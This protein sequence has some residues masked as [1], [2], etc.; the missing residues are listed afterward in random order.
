VTFNVTE[1]LDN[2]EKYL[3]DPTL[4]VAPY[5]CLVTGSMMGKSRLIKEMTRQ[6]PTIFICARE[7]PG[8]GGFPPTTPK[9]MIWF[10]RGAYAVADDEDQIKGDAKGINII[11][12]LQYS[13]FLI[14]TLHILALYLT[15]DDFLT[16]YEVYKYASQNDYSWMWR[17]F[18]DIQT[19]EDEKYVGEF[20]GKV[21]EGVKEEGAGCFTTEGAKNYYKQKY[22]IT[23]TNAYNVVKNNLAKAGYDVKRKFTLLFV[24][25]EARQFCQLA[26]EDG[27]TLVDES[28]IF[29]YTG[30]SPKPDVGAKD[31]FSGFRAL[32]RAIRL[33]C[34]G[35]EEK[36]IRLF[37]LFTDTT[38]RLTNF[39][40]LPRES[41]SLREVQLELGV[42]GDQQFEPLMYFTTIDAYA[43]IY[44]SCTSVE[45]V[46]DPERLVNFGRAGWRDMYYIHTKKSVSLASETAQAK[47]VNL[48]GRT[49]IQIPWKTKSPSRAILIKL[50]AVLAPRISLTAGPYTLEASE[51]VASHMAVLVKT[52]EDRH[53]TRMF[54][55]SE[56][57]SAE[58]AAH[59]LTTFGWSK[60]LQ[61][62]QHYVQT[63]IVDAG[64]RGELLSKIVCLMA[65]DSTNTKPMEGELFPF[66]R[67]IRVG[68]F[69]NHLISFDGISN[70]P[71]NCS[72][73]T[74]TGYILA[75]V[76]SHISRQKLQKFLSGYV[77]FTHFAR[78]DYIVNIAT[79]AQFFNRGAAIMCKSC[80]PGYDHIIPVM[81]DDAN[82]AQFGPLEGQWNAKQL[83]HGRAGLSGIFIDSKNYTSD[84]N[85][86]THVQH[87]C[88]V[89]KGRGKN[90][91]GEPTD[92]VFLSIIQDFGDGENLTN[93]VEIG[94]CSSHG[95]TLRQ[96]HKNQTQIVMRGVSER[97]YECLKWSNE[98]EQTEKEMNNRVRYL[99]EL[100]SA[101]TNFLDFQK[102]EGEAER[103][104][105]I[106]RAI[107]DFTTISL[108]QGTDPK[109]DA[110]WAKTR[111]NVHEID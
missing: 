11:P 1:I 16:K 18:A 79:L 28:D 54:Y 9:L 8:Q 53:F 36:T 93:H 38:S 69:L 58:G 108:E 66:S 86:A 62:L 33:L 106:E 14:S 101:Q 85:W 87:V 72:A 78:V 57:M 75:T 47:L 95:M 109:R 29:R 55:P 49:T 82:V 5:T 61:A 81:F 60:S 90:F 21:L 98:K 13:L 74:V 111:G 6:L 88:P 2:M 41:R 105:Q 103:N 26:T 83:E 100:R 22:R 37:G 44:N 56:P 3:S 32:K 12:T 20:W 68:D 97:T 51:L 7:T 77:F 92:N 42:A 17:F 91:K 39:Q 31:T 19:L 50:L 46:A 24:C 43:R 48:S 15:R 4:Y 10:R 96:R 52:A 59:L 102:V 80:N 104:F 35:N 107:R 99:S 84:Q 27:K 71:E 45:H 63:G 34:F 94:P 73:T 89:M 40:P 64:F 30:D 76:H 70:K 110:A 25:D 23:A 65:A 67:P